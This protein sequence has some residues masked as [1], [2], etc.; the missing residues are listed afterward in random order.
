MTS[1]VVPVVVGS[2]DARSDACE[3]GSKEDVEAGE[4]ES[5]GMIS[6]TRFAVLSLGSYS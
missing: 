4:P 1:E 3:D 6:S 5:D 2:D